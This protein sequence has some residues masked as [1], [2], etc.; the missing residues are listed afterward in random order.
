MTT[1]RTPKASPRRRGFRWRIGLALVP[2]VGLVTLAC[3]VF[4]LVACKAVGHR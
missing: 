1:A 2:A 4:A 3:W